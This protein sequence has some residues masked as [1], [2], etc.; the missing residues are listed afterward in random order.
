[1]LADQASPTSC[2]P[3][4]VGPNIPLF[5][6]L[7]KA[8][9]ESH[10]YAIGDDRGVLLALSE[11]AQRQGQQVSVLLDINVG[12]DRTG[13]SPADAPALYAACARMPGLMVCGLHAYDGHHHQEDFARREQVRHSQM[14]LDSAISQIRDQGLPRELLVLAGTPSFPC[15]ALHREGFLSPAPPF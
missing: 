11:A 9:P 10:L 2:W 13:V 5:L 3:I 8:C 4:L 6:A 14:E 12:M 1:M 7:R 15:H